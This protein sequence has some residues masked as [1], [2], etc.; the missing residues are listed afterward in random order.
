MRTTKQQVERGPL[1]GP[2]GVIRVLETPHRSSGFPGSSLLQS[3]S[4]GGEAIR[5]EVR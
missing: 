3:A 1:S 4:H 2:G 5:L